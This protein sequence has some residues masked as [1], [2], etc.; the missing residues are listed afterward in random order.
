MKYEEHLLNSIM[1]E[2]LRVI[3]TLKPISIK[4][5]IFNENKNDIDF[6]IN[7]VISFQGIDVGSSMK[8]QQTNNSNNR[9]EWLL[10]FRKIKT[11]WIYHAFWIKLNFIIYQNIMNGWI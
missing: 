10:T 4:I 5:Q 2:F 7:S 3:C 9:K 6:D 1:N 8:N 11:K